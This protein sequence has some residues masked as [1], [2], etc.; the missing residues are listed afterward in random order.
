M[1]GKVFPKERYLHLK[2]IGLQWMKPKIILQGRVQFSTGGIL[3]EP[4]WPNRCNS[5]SNS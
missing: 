4:I 2:K 1:E 3:R 5:G